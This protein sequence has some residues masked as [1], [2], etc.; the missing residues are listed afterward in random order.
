MSVSVE[1]QSRVLEVSNNWKCREIWKI[2][3][4]FHPTRTSH[5]ITSHMKP[6][7]QLKTTKTPL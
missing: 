4:V 5:L 6:S 3:F 1:G 2:G 7:E